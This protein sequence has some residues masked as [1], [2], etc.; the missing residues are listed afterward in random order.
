MIMNFKAPSSTHETLK[1]VVCRQSSIVTVPLFVPGRQNA[2]ERFL[3][4]GAASIGWGMETRMW[5]K[6]I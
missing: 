4:P 1:V 2:E 3:F 6:E 5:R